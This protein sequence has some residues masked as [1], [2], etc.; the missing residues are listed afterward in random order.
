MWKLPQGFAKAGG[1][2]D[3]ALFDN[4]VDPMPVARKGYDAM[5]KGKLNVM[6]GLIGYQKIMMRIVPLAPKKMMMNF[7]YNMQKKGSSKK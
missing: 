2:S 3:T 5:L 7:V 6:S 1:L 4:S